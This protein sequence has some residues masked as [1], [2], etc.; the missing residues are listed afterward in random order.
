MVEYKPYDLTE[1]AR[2]IAEKYRLE[3]RPEGGQHFGTT[4]ER[5]PLAHSFDASKGRREV[6]ISPKELQSIAFGTHTI[7]L[8]GVEQLADASQTRAIGDAIYYATR[9]IDGERTLRQIID[10]VLRDV[11]SKGL[12]VL[13]PRPVGDYAVFRALELGAA[14]N[15]LRTLLV[16]KKWAVFLNG[17]NGLPQVFNILIRS[18]I[19]QSYVVK[20]K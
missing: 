10:G 4:S 1:T 15:R 12:D 3:R 8:G 6:K 18:C 11:S 2:A 17:R 16:R 9:Y 20:Y 19:Q 13:S 7:D 5:I 14:M